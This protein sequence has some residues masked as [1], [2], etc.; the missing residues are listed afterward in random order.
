M[1]EKELRLALVCYGGV[2][3]AIY[4]HGVSKEILKLARASAD[5]QAGTEAG[6][7][8]AN[9]DFIDTEA[10]YLDLLRQIGGDIDLHVVVDVIAG[11]SAGGINGILLGRA[12]A[13]DLAFD[14]L[15]SMW[16]EKADVAE[17]MATKRKAS[18]WS[19]WFLRPM[20]Q[21]G[22]SRRKMAH[23]APD[24]EMRD[25]LSLFIRSRWF[26]PPFGGPDLCET[27]YDDM[28]AMSSG[29]HRRTSLTPS[30]Q[31]LD[32][33]VTLTDFFGYSQPIPLHD[34]D[35]ITEREH[36]HTLQFRHRYFSGENMTTDFDLPDLPALVFAARATAS[37]PGAFPPARIAE[38]DRL[39]E[40]RKTRWQ[41]REKF[42]R[43]NFAVYDRSGQDPMATAFIDGSV[44]N[45]KPFAQAIESI[46]QRPA[47]RQV[48]RRLVYIDPD[49]E[50]PNTSAARRAPSMLRTLKGALS[51]IPRNE[52]IRDELDW[53]NGFNLRVRR[54]KTVL[55]SSMPRIE[56]MVSEVIGTETASLP[57][58]AD[59][60]D[61]RAAAGR[62]AAEKSG[63]A[64]DGYMR[65]RIDAVVE[66]L[67]TIL[68]Q[69]TAG[70]PNRVTIDNWVGRLR[71]WADRTGVYPHEDG[72]GNS[73]QAAF[74][75]GLD[76]DYR[77]R[78]LRFV[79]RS[80][81]ELYAAHPED[82]TGS[83]LDSIKGQIYDLLEVLR[84]CRDVGVLSHRCRNM[85]VAIEAGRE[86][87]IGAL[88]GLLADDFALSGMGRRVDQA[89]HHMA[90]TE[91]PGEAQRALLNSFLGFAFWDVLAFTVTSWRDV[92]EF[93]EIRVDRI[94]P[95]D[96]NSL[97]HGGAED[98]LK[99]VGMGHFAA[100]FSRRHRENDYLW[101]RLHGAERV[102]DIVMSSAKL[103]GAGGNI[104]V[105]AMKRRAFTAILE[106]EALHLPNSGDLLAE[107]RQEIATL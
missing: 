5:H 82:M 17:L 107:L 106:A 26:R 66:Q 3:L 93:D 51:D 13:L 34:P 8:G 10:V 104:D 77:A 68:T 1:R 80:L 62:M 84:R 96:A 36:R 43:S 18:L 100:F 79:V 47:H 42:M 29:K 27:L 69:A 16:L 74:L 7:R 65:L 19:R 38:V 97:H 45:N 30:G 64:Y 50:K 71:D 85:A 101:G 23:L 103:E 89:L 53:I 33:F 105:V 40:N 4:M 49:P 15:R 20:V 72:Q 88:I 95:D 75:N 22:L 76:A 46:K 83:A 91:L 92:G 98:I 6:G 11:A 52:P 32:L 28:A 31:W 73:A 86:S 70:G 37:F 35:Q 56:G 61:W 48:D 59:L 12:L 81:N 14:P 60:G 63:Y 102:I 41:G 67:A 94:S 87:N 55:N 24:E 58:M 54:L 9:S 25:K 78:R 44:L 90:G 21:W 39:V 2:S 57:D 99:G